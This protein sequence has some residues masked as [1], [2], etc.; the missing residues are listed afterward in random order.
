MVVYLEL[1][2]EGIN[3]AS[4]D[5]FDNRVNDLLFLLGEE[6][7][8]PLI[9]ISQ[10]SELKDSGSSINAHAKEAL[11]TIDNILLYQRVSSGQTALKLEPV[12]VG[13][14]IRDVSEVMEPLMRTAGC[15]TEVRIQHSLSPVDVDRQVLN[16]ALQGLWQ[17]LMSTMTDPSEI[18]CRAH[19][20]KGGIRLS[21]TSLKAD[22]TNLSFKRANVKS[23]QP[24]SAVAG[25]V[26]DLLAAHGMFEL[27]GSS[28]TKTEGKTF[29]GFG[30]TLKISQ[31][32][33]IV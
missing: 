2:N 1:R 17:A 27:L 4:N 21:L 13:S 15:R 32:L 14:T 26:T 11:R 6:I 5:K 22:V 9:A 18:V 33:Q 8:Q 28:L 24:M 29:S 12:H 10:L 30:V 16:G 23:F 25:P 31:Q 7:K 3:I 20:T 19:R